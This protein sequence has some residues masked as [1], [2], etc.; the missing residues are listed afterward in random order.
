MPGHIVGTRFLQGS[1]VKVLVKHLLPPFPRTGLGKK[2]FS[3]SGPREWREE[4][5][6]QYFDGGT[7]QKPGPYNMPRHEGIR[8]RR[9]KLISFYEYDTWEFY[10]LHKDPNELVG[11]LM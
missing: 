3:E 4:V 11:I 2:L 7:L 5:L 8:N 10:D 9:Y 1:S 6:Y